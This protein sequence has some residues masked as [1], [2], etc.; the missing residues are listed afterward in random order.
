MAFMQRGH[1][2]LFTLQHVPS[3]LSSTAAAVAGNE[4]PTYSAKCWSLYR[5]TRQLGMSDVVEIAIYQISSWLNDM[6]HYFCTKSIN[7]KVVFH[8]FKISAA[9]DSLVITR[10]LVATLPCVN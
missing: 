3:V 4:L 2:L 10:W 1:Q 6:N 8:D 9:S 7:L 5:C